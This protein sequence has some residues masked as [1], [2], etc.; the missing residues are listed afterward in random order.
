MLYIIPGQAFFGLDI[1]PRRGMVQLTGRMSYEKA[2]SIEDPA[3]RDPPK[4]RHHDHLIERHIRSP[5]RGS[6]KP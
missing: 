5:Q 6:R 1:V 4:K 3:Q 2:S